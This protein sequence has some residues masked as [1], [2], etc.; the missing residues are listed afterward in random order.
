MGGGVVRYLFPVALRA[1]L[2]ELAEHRRTLSAL[3]AVTRDRAAEDAAWRLRL[4]L[5]QVEADVLER[6]RRRELA[7]EDAAAALRRALG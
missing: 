5:A 7:A 4:E 1:A 2:E 3:L 6:W